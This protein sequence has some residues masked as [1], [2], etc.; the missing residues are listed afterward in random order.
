MGKASPKNKG[1]LPFK[2][3]RAKNLRKRYLKPGALAQI[4]DSRATLRS[5][6]DIG[7]KRVLVL[8]SSKVGKDLL[9]GSSAST[10]PLLLHKGIN[11]RP[12]DVRRPPKSPATPKTPRVCDWESESRLESLPLD[13]LVKIM[14]QLHHDQLRAV[15]HV[16][17][18]IRAA[19]LLARQLHFNYTTPDRSRQPVLRMKTPPAPLPNEHLFFMSVGDENGIWVSHPCTPRPS[20]FGHTSRLL[21]TDM[22]QVTASLFQESIKSRKPPSFPRPLCRSKGSS[23]V[24]LYEDELCQAVS[25]NKLL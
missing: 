7:K 22:R 1:P 9:L 21:F 23:K 13:L 3:K 6:T 16:S 25:Q 8:D 18:R 12:L 10:C 15:F 4:R 14:C 2:Q 11:G 5:C 17:R 24:S 19:V 20:R